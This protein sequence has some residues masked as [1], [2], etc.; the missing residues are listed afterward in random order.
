MK[1]R[2]YYEEIASAWNGEDAFCHYD[3]G[4]V[5]EEQATVAAEIVD[6]VDALIASLNEF[7][8]V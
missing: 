2:T 6:K 7:D 4:T 8:E 3:G 1:I 5:N